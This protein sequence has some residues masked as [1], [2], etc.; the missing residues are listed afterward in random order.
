MGPA[1][2]AQ[3][4]VRTGSHATD[5]ALRSRAPGVWRRRWEPAVARIARAERPTSPL[6]FI[7]P[8][9]AALVLERD[10]DGSRLLLAA[11]DR[12][13]GG[14]FRYF[15][16]DEVR[17]SRP[18]DFSHDPIADT[19][20]PDVRG[21]R[22]DY[23]HD[24]PADPKWIWELNRLQHLPLL[25]E[26][27]L[28]SGDSRYA[29]C[30]RQD[31]LDWIEQSAPGQGIAW[32]NAF[33]PA[34]RAVSIVLVYDAL[35]AW[36][37]LGLGDRD[38][39]LVSLWQHARW[40]VR[41]PSTGSSANNHLLTELAALVLVAALAPELAESATGLEQALSLLA[42][43]A[44]LQILPDGGTAEQAFAYGV[45]V[46]DW[47]LVVAAALDSAQ[48]RHE[49]AIEAA[50]ARAADALAAQLGDDEPE[51][52]YG[53]ADDSRAV[54]LDGRDRRSARGVCSALAARLGH[55]GAR[56]AAGELDTAALWLLGEEGAR[57]F[58]ETRAAERPRSA[59]LPDTGLAVLRRGS[60]RVLVDVG[61]LGYLSIAAHGHADALQV[62]VADGKHE[63]VAD[64]GP[65]SFFAR[66][67]L[68]RPFRGTAAHATVSVDGR[69]QS[70]FG[71][72]FLWL[73]HAQARILHLDLLGG[74]VAGEHDGYSRLAE[75]VRHRR[76]VAL[77]VD[78]SLLVYDRLD[79]TG[80]HQHLQ[81]W[82]FHPDV[83][84]RAD[85]E[86]LQ[87]SRGGEHIGALTFAAQPSGTIELVRGREEPPDGWWSR[88][89]EVLEP[90]WLARF[91]VEA[92]GR[93]EIAALLSNERS[94]LELVREGDATRVI[95][96]DGASVVVDFDREESPV[97]VKTARVPTEA[98]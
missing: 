80:A 74:V 8:E 12:T 28:L 85:A 20:W 4:A 43:E 91:R 63:L 34:V 31:L 37:G 25:A 2:I 67:E 93:V 94:P 52:A 18:I 68:R 61:P 38:A 23:R 36:H 47:L 35:R 92:R 60:R 44:E 65:G 64:P 16:Y 86:S 97:T 69:D 87:L 66:P 88:R 39:I 42:R 3:R 56:R 30:A 77:L 41:D 89:L 6:G 14:C 79:S 95:M 62:A 10:P 27:W 15:G 26:A 21:K 9:R 46:L 76:V 70:E 98:R 13:V 59:Y 32:A 17:L 58:A 33:E 51:P 40:I 96:A 19:R 71:G 50:L 29:E 73:R 1:E 48:R 78:G 83:D 11:A 24:A 75:P 82:P 45:V 53:D 22:L 72:P 57:R 84:V 54:V 49:P 90:A 55:A 81:S 5:D 7:S